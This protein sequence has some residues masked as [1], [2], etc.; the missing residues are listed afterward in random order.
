MK[1][2]NLISIRDLSASD[3][4]EIFELAAEMKRSP[5]DYRDAL[6]GRTLGMIFE[7]KSTRTRVSFEVGIYQLGGMGLFLS[8]SDIQLGRGETVADTARVLSRYVDGVMA[9]TYAHADMVELARHASVPVVNGLSDLLHPC[10]A[11]TD[12]FTLAEKKQDLK[13]G[14]IAYVGDGNNMCHSL[15]YGANKV[16][17]NIAIATPEHYEPKAIIMKSANREAAHVGVT[18]SLSHDPA[19][20]VEGA[21]AV[22]TD[23]WASMGQEVEAEKRKAA[24][25]DYQVNADLMARAKPDAVF[26]HCLPAHRGE[27]VTAEVLDGPQS[28]VFDQ[29]ENRLHVQKAILYLLMGGSS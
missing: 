11:L 24:F 14:K 18:V 6:R 16:G 19:G 13:G 28:V 3:V 26:M 8:S 1:A 10:Q 4:S 21:D 20:A 22:Y 27:E 17:M 9:R 23:V 29:A 5:E 15:L 25:Q 12:Y 2:K 7:K